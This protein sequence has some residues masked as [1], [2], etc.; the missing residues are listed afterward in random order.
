MWIS[1]LINLGSLGKWVD[2]HSFHK[3]CLLISCSG[4]LMWRNQMLCSEKGWSVFQKLWDF[5][6]CENILKEHW[7]TQCRGSFSILIQSLVYPSD[8]WWPNL[9][10]EWQPRKPQVERLAQATTTGGNFSKV[11]FSQYLFLQLPLISLLLKLVT[12]SLLLNTH[13]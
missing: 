5:K 11:L 7:I 2:L 13:I 10:F 4:E 8:T 12:Q 3:Q 9:G 1:Y 6:W